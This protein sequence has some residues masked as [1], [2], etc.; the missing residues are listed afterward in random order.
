MSEDYDQDVLADN[1]K[2]YAPLDL[3]DCQNLGGVIN[4]DYETVDLMGD[5]VKVEYI[6]ENDQGEIQRGGI[7]LKEE[8]GTKLWRVG[9]VAFVGAEAPKNLTVGCLIR[10]P[11]DRGIPAISQG[12]KYIYLNA[13]RIFEIVKKV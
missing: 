13:S 10:F 1:V 2:G 5:L 11:S 3:D 4:E 12:K 7:W 6:D 9:R 8:V